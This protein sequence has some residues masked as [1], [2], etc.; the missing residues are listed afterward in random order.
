MTNFSTSLV[1][2]L[3]EDNLQLPGLLFS[4]PKKTKTAAIFLHG[5][6]SSS[7]FYSVARAHA[8]AEVF[9]HNKI[10][11][12]MFNNRG[13][14]LIKKL[15]RVDDV[16]KEVEEVHLG[17]AYELIKDCVLD[18]NGAIAY[19]QARGYQ[20]LYLIGH[21][22]G[23]NKICVF[24]HHQPGN[25]LAGYLLLGGGDDT[26]MIYQQLGDRATLQKYLAQAQ[27]KIEQGQGERFVPRAF[28]NGLLSYQSFDDVANPDGEYNC[29][30]FYEWQERVE[31][32]SKPLFNYFKQ[33]SKPAL[34]IYGEHDEHAPAKSG[35]KAV[36]ILQQQAQ[37]AN[38]QLID[39]AVIQDA[40]HGFHEKETALGEA[41][42]GWIAKQK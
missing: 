37:T 18:I 31:L 10:A 14:H 29:F 42:V 41:M 26:G 20:Q 12:L 5:C 7:V 8:L 1:Q 27:K 16:G 11:L 6:G 32:S 13:A 17:T 35:K 34:V 22:T 33:L 4:P 38:N 19:L 21:S 9:A 28:F 30:P 3:S 36:E 24:D 2:F 25:E 23:A 40:D 15:N 39:F